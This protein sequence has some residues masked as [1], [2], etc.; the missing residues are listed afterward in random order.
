MRVAVL[1]GEIAFD[2]QRRIITGILEKASESNGQVYLF[3]GDA[4]EYQPH[5]KYE[6]GEY[7]IY[8]LPDFSAFDGVI[9]VPDTIHS[10]ETVKKVTERIRKA[11]V[12]CVSINISIDGF[13]SVKMG[14]SE[15]LKN[16]VEHLFNRHGVRNLFY[17]SG[18]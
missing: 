9:F 8:N 2:S 5:D 14:N 18:P 15:G 13:M 3:I 6:T 11:G 4:E 1:I 16:I 10:P 12:P 17:I 7:N